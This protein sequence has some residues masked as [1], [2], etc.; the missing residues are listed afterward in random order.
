MATKTDAKKALLSVGVSPSTHCG[1]TV[2][3]DHQIIL[4]GLIP[5]ILASVWHWGI[6]A[7]RVMA[8]AMVTGVATEA[9]CSHCMKQSVIVRDFSAVVSCLY[10]AFL[11]PAS[12]PWWIVM[13][14]AVLCITLGK[15]AF[16]GLG[17][18]PL[19]TTL[20][21]WA[22]LAVSWPELMNPHSA[23]LNTSLVDPLVHLKLFGAAA[24]ADMSVWDMLL[25]YQIG[26][27][28]ATQ[29]LLL[30]LGGLWIIA[31]GVVRW[32]ISLGFFA[33]VLVASL[34]PYLADSSAYASPLFHLAT[35]WASS[36]ARR[37]PMLI[38]GAFAGVMV[39][40]IRM[41]GIYPDGAPFAILLA[42][43]VAP[44]LDGI[45]PKPFGMK[46][47]GRV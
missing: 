11:M 44:L 8:L 41:F 1:R 2:T 4:I 20:V 14:G 12:A 25:G 6:P 36:P 26:G 45:R 29:G 16:G 28:G 23:L 30:I 40:V 3:K 5:V 35:E 39:I 34:I 22:M 32:E 13:L 27:L 33:G 19:N 24:V 42:N 47:G 21:G 43:L 46:K 37:V 18:N 10:L 17:A 7:A 31:R 15:M 38:Y 9:L